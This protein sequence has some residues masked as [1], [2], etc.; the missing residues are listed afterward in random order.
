M[1]EYRV[2]LHRR[3]AEAEHQTLTSQDK[4]EVAKVI[5]NNYLTSAGGQSYKC[6]WIEAR[7]KVTWSIV[8]NTYR[9][10]QVVSDAA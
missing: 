9:E 8:E 1:V 2:M 3:G 5:L 6:G 4:L 10:G 7:P